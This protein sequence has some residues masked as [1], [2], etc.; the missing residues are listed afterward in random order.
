MWATAL[1]RQQEAPA[2]KYPCW[3]QVMAE[4]KGEVRGYFWVVVNSKQEEGLFRGYHER[5]ME[6]VIAL[7]EELSK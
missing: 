6:R 2:P 5:L 4:D 3:I 1:A 7:R